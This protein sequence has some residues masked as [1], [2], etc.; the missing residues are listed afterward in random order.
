MGKNVLYISNVDLYSKFLPGVRIKIDGQRKAFLENGFNIDVLYPTKSSNVSIRLMTGEV[1]SFKGG[2]SVYVGKNVLK[3]LFKHV[4]IAWKGSI[5]Y[6]YCYDYIKSNDY[7]VIYLRFYFPGQDLIKFI[8]KIK[9]DLPHVIIFLEYP[10]QK[11]KELASVTLMGRMAYS[12]NESLIKKL[13]Y[14]ADYIISLTNT[15]ELFGRPVVF[16]PNGFDTSNIR[17]VDVPQYSDTF[18]MLAVAS[19]VIISHGFDKVIRGIHNYYKAGGQQKILF[20]LISNSLSKVLGDLKKMAKDL[21]VEHCI[22][23]E[24]PLDRD[25]L[26]EVYKNVHI[27]VGTL[28]QHRIGLQ[29][30]FSLKHRE[31]GAFGL[32]FIMNH[33]DLH[34]N[35]SEY[36]Y[37]EEGNDNPIDINAVLSFYFKIRE[38]VKDYP[39][40]FSESVKDRISWNNQMKGVFSI[41]REANESSSTAL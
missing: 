18:I 27:G 2:R 17:P 13:N 34:F 1:V 35:T 9:R 32:P 16:M 28:A 25:E 21:D 37:I 19:D 40:R 30:N 5:N 31:Y 41:I 14:N 6:A 24:A 7:S 3:K 33:G 38:N 36:V 12:F 20:R 29:E 22:S 10:T 39:S 11:V 4:V 23:F 8:E 15:K 26:I